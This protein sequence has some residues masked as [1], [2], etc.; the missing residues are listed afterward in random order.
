MVLILALMFGVNL[1]VKEN[2]EETAVETRR[3]AFPQQNINQTNIFADFFDNLIS[4]EESQEFTLLAVGDMML[5]REVERRTKLLDDFHAP[6]LET[7]EMLSN[8]D[9]TFGNLETP[10]LDGN[11]VGVNQMYFRA[12]PRFAEGLS[13][14]GF[15]VLSLANN[16]TTNFGVDGLDSTLSLLNEAGISYVGAGYDK[17]EAWSPI[18]KE[19]NGLKIAFLAYTDDVITLFNPVPNRS[20]V[21]LMNLNSLQAS[22]EEL[23]PK[24][25]LIVVSMHSGVEYNTTNPTST[26]L[27][28]AHTAIDAGADLVL[29]HHPHVLQPVEEYKGKL[30]FYSLG[31]FVFDQMFSEATR[32][33][34]AVKFFF[35]SKGRYNKEPQPTVD[36][37][38]VEF[39]PYLIHDYYLPKPAS[40]SDAERMLARISDKIISVNLNSGLAQERWFYQLPKQFDLNENGINEEYLLE[41][42]NLIIKESDKVFWQSPE[43]WRVDNLAFGD[44][45]NDGREEFLLSLW[46]KGSYG[47]SKPFWV[48]EDDSYAQHLFIYQLESSG[49]KLFWGSSNLEAPL[50]DFSV[51]DLDENGDYELIASEASYENPLVVDRVVVLNFKHWNLFVEE[52]IEIPKQ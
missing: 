51:Q 36:L 24:V 26:Q 5:S 35:E 22:V 18:V 32:E 45:N 42:N 12:D 28:F 3:A 20:T 34:V 49:P 38:A 2:V 16:H 11:P 30:I 7:K 27:E 50:L 13:W 6:F 44:I 10:L 15:D 47:S 43:E 37:T 19:V 23:R 8:A 40:E 1:E 9:L 33:A 17:S 31:N 4:F 25:D 21:A 14:A 29:G 48:T 52:E 41:E 39:F 46:K